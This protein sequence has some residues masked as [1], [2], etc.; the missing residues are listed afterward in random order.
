M[1]CW[2]E[3]FPHHDFN[4]HHL[5]RVLLWSDPAFPS[6]LALIRNSV[7]SPRFKIARYGSTVHFSDV[8][9]HKGLTSPD[10]DVSQG[11]FD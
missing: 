6:F 9:L 8:G 5:K 4:N 11:T 3:H 10:L 2:N 7:P 1:K